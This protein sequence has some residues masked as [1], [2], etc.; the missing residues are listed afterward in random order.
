M[1]IVILGCGRMGSLLANTLSRSGHSIVII[2]KNVDSFRRLE[3]G[4]GGEKLTGLGVEE[5]TLLRA[6]VDNADAFIAVTNG[7]NTNLMAAQIAQRRFNVP[8]VIVRVYDPIRAQTYGKFG[9]TVVCTSIV[10]SGLI[11]DLVMNQPQ[12]PIEEYLAM[13]PEVDDLLPRLPS[14]VEGEGKGA[15]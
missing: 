13:G 2:D 8:K 11:R 6:G 15:G 3:P 14:E 7:D 5:E 12:R 9:M 1:R 4:Y 10:G